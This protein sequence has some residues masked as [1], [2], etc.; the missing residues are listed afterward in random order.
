MSRI[1]TAGPSISFVKDLSKFK[2]LGQFHISYGD[3]LLVVADEIGVSIQHVFS[4]VSPKEQERLPFETLET[5][6]I[7]VYK[8]T[9]M[10]QIVASWIAL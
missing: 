8:N 9:I 1:N 4:I 7:K 2:M 5:H 3:T 10:P 6:T